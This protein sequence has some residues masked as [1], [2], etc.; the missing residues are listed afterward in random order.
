MNIILPKNLQKELKTLQTKNNRDYYNKYNSIKETENNIIITE[1]NIKN[2]NEYCEYIKQEIIKILIKF[3]YIIESPQTNI[4]S[5][6]L[7]GVAVI[8]CNECNGILLNEMLH[9][10]IF[11]ELPTNDIICI[12]SIFASYKNEKSSQFNKYYGH[13]YKQISEIKEKW[14]ECENSAKIIINKDFWEITDGYIDIT[15]EWA[16]NADMN[17]IMQYLHDMNEY[18]GNFVKNMLK[19]YNI[20]INFKKMCELTGHMDISMRLI[21]LDKKLLRDIVNVNSLY[22]S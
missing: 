21:D 9:S 20:C 18:E 5:L 7:Y 16:N 4:K 1:K 22:L 19:I 11:D 14:I 3:N 8:N 2:I 10:H 17:V 13:I 12:L 15:Y 6:D